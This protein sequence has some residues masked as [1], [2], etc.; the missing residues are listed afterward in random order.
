MYD[1]EMILTAHKHSI[2]HLNEIQES[3]YCGCFY[4]LNTFSPNEIAEWVEE[5][6]DKEPTAI[7][8]KCGID[9]VIGSKS[10]YPVTDK[11]FLEEMCSYWF[12]AAS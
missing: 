1:K 8:P 10:Y 12:S 3:V 2:F 9:A 5:Q 6:E 11:T 4:C 7:C